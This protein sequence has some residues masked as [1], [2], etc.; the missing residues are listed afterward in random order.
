MYQIE[1]HSFSGT[2][3]WVTDAIES[4][5]MQGQQNPKPGPVCM[6]GRTRVKVRVIGH[7]YSALLWYEPRARDA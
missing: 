3:T 7:L 1:A 5:P 4:S 2:K 6:N